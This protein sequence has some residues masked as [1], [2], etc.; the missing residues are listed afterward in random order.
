MLCAVAGGEIGDTGH[1]RGWHGR[2]VTSAS[3]AL[4]SMSHR[5]YRISKGC[6]YLTTPYPTNA[7]RTTSTCSGSSSSVAS[8]TI[9]AMQHIIVMCQRYTIYDSLFVVLTMI[10]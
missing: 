6:H 2:V 10:L 5:S 8:H 1:E 7:I 3:A 9:E 4:V